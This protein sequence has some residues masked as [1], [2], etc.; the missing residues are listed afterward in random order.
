[1]IGDSCQG[2]LLAEQ[3]VEQ[4]LGGPAAIAVGGMQV[5]IDSRIGRETEAGRGQVHV[6]SLSSPLSARWFASRYCSAVNR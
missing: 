6:E 5:Q 3:M 2:E 4:R 1:M